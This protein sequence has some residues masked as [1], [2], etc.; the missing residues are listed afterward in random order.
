[1]GRAVAGAVLALVLLAACGA[2]EA[3]RP[4]GGES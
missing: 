4:A 2:K 3:A 1:M